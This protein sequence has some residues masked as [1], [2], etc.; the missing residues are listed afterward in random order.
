[1]D[2]P[3]KPITMDAL[4][5]GTVVNLKGKNYPT[6]PGLL[7]LAH[8]NGLDR[9]CT[10]LLKS[11]PDG[12]IVKATANG[13]RG[14]YEAHGDASPKNVSKNIATALIRMAET[15]A[16][17]RALRYYLGIGATTYEEL[18]PE[19]FQGG[20]RPKPR[21]K[22][23][24]KPEQ[25]PEKIGKPDAGAFIREMLKKSITEKQLLAIV[26]RCWGFPSVEHL[27]RDMLDRLYRKIMDGPSEDDK[28]WVDAIQNNHEQILQT[29]GRDPGKHPWRIINAVSLGLL[30]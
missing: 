19:A 18:P 29:L 28:L 20:P 23:K 21:P 12:A 11:E 13:N 3:N 8:A 4:P 17:G 22:P 25:K 6:H 7:A 10:E 5:P 30:S 27:D 24:Q 16:I 2:A 9:I 26:D 1:M 15:R 14:T